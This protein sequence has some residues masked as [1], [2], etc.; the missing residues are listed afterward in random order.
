LSLNVS[1]N[2]RGKAINR[3]GLYSFDSNFQSVAEFLAAAN[4]FTDAQVRG[5][6]IEDENDLEIGRLVGLAIIHVEIKDLDRLR[7]PVDSLV[8]L[9]E[10][11]R[12]S[13]DREP[14]ASQSETLEKRQITLLIQSKSGGYLGWVQLQL[15]SENTIRFLFR[16][17][18]DFELDAKLVSAAIHSLEEFLYQELGV[19]S[20]DVL[21][22]SEEL[23]YIRIFSA[24]GYRLVLGTESPTP[25]PN[26]AI[27]DGGGKRGLS[28]DSQALL[29]KDLTNSRLA[30]PKILTAGPSIS[31]REVTYVSEAA[32]KGWNA[33]H[34]DYLAKFQAEFAAYVGSGFAIPT[35][36]CTG[37][38]HLSLL[39]LGI[40]P[41]DEVLV[42]EITWVATASAV[43]Y[44]GATPVFVDVDPLT[45]CLDVNSA[46]DLVSHRTKAIMPVHLYGFAANMSAIMTFANQHGLLVVEDAAPAIGTLVGNQAA[47]TFGHFGAYSFQG[48]KMLVTGEGG[49][50]VTSSEE[51]YLRALKIQD[52]GRQPGTFWIDELGHKYKMNNIT[53]ALGLAQLERSERQIEQKQRISSWYHEGFDSSP[54]IRM[55]SESLGTR[56]IHWM[57]SIVLQEGARTSTKELMDSLRNQGIDSR[58]LFPAISQYPIWGKSTA[59]GPIAKNLG[60]RAINLPSGVGLSR[61][62]VERVISA[63]LEAI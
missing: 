19:E 26:V 48:A 28:L 8:Y 10:L 4:S 34:S 36:S 58:P 14:F 59:P 1:R 18:D 53:A 60:E 44:V 56:S 3:L 31:S 42:P 54:S 23:D 46:A 13:Q 7:L 33:R 20:L 15:Q 11:L 32:R 24:L 12:K 38:L 55:Q 35:S 22:D 17:S 50:L 21:V 51:L 39:A 63:V 43:R 57:N 6:P 41:G 29:S 30:I 25:P 27:V 9:N 40:G 16:L 45:W 5:I 47:G 2:P 52:H 62:S 49:M 61:R 37:A